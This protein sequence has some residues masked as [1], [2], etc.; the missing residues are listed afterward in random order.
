MPQLPPLNTVQELSPE[1]FRPPIWIPRPSVQ[2]PA[3]AADADPPPP[4]VLVRLGHADNARRFIR[5]VYHPRFLSQMVV[6]D[7]ASN[8]CRAL[9]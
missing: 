5:R 3:P 1:R 4:P 9:G 7:V 6:Y 8:V 2:P